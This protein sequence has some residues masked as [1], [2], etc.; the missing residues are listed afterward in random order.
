VLTIKLFDIY[1]NRLKEPSRLLLRTESNRQF[2]F[3]VEQ[4]SIE[5]AGLSDGPTNI[6]KMQV[7]S[8]SYHTVG[9][10]VAVPG[11][12]HILPITLPMKASKVHRMD[13]PDYDAL[14]KEYSRLFSEKDYDNLSMLQTA[15]LLNILSLLDYYA[16]LPHL[17][18]IKSFQQD[19]ILAAVDD[20]LHGILTSSQQQTF[21]PVSG[22]LHDIPKGHTPA[23][24]YKS[25]E[26]YGNLQLTLFRRGTS[27]LADIDIDDAAG[28]KHIFQVLRNSIKGPTHPYNIHQILVGYQHLPS[29][30]RIHV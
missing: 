1:G 28:L 11:H 18:L 24:S 23:G 22:A 13:F 8:P 21:Q 6:Y 4:G 26:K 3:T 20:S 15:G 17:T 7:Q 25:P 10:L 16:L 12:N 27:Y 30:Y 9:Q 29:L 14:P 2:I 19:R 5:L